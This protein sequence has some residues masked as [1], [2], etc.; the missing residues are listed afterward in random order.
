MAIVY[1]HR[2]LDKNEVFYVGIGKKESRAYSFVKSRR[3]KIWN[4]IKSRSEVEVEI[5]ARDLSWELACGLEQLMIAEYGRIDL[6]TGTLANLTDGGEGTINAKVWNKGLTGFVSAR[7]GVKL[8]EE[9]K[10]K[11]S[12]TKMGM[13]RGGKNPRAKI[14]LDLL[15]GV[16]YDCLK[17]GCEAVGLNYHTENGRINENRSNKRFIYV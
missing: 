8:S 17:D 15:T 2:R 4:D 7:K 3:N 12:K 10:N 14:V 16:F 9:Q 1:R 11:I 13:Q 5:V 6:G